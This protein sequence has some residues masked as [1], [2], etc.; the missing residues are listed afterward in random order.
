MNNHIITITYP[1]F[2]YLHHNFSEYADIASIHHLER[3]KQLPVP[4]C[5]KDILGI[6]GDTADPQYPIFRNGAPPDDSVTLG[7]GNNAM[8]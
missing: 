2:R 7:T 6:L 1:S 4:T 3:I 5:S 8:L